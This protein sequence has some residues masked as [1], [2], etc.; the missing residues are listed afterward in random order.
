M[1]PDSIPSPLYA[2]DLEQKSNV[3]SSLDSFYSRSRF[4]SVNSFLAGN[5]AV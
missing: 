5:G 1:L 4:N 3:D 2:A